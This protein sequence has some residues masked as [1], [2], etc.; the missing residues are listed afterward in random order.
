MEKKILVVMF[1]L[2]CFLFA[3]SEPEV[4]SRKLTPTGALAHPEPIKVH[5]ARNAEPVAQEPAQ[6]EKTAAETLEEVKQTWVDEPAAPSVKTASSIYGTVETTKTGK[7]ALR[8]KT[9]AA[10]SVGYGLT[11]DVDADDTFGSKYHS[12]SGKLTNVP[13]G[14]GEDTDY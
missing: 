7:D 1:I 9:R 2:A 4:T 13:E 11:E 3:C 5:E 8:E 14:Y 10:Y 6:P 12:S